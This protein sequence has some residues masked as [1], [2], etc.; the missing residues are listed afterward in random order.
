M[1]LHHPV[2]VNNRKVKFAY[3]NSK[4]TSTGGGTYLTRALAARNETG[5]DVIV[6]ILPHS[7]NTSK[8]IERI[9]RGRE[10]LMSAVKPLILPFKIVVVVGTNQQYL[11]DFYKDM[12][13]SD[14][15]Y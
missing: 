3:L 13:W 15:K 9:K 5:A 12:S 10:D 7:E 4:V 1:K 14:V 6:F 2:V 8:N 11:E